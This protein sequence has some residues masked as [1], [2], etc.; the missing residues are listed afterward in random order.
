MGFSLC[1]I[2]GLLVSPVSWT[3]HWTLAV[4]ALLLLALRVVRE[5]SKVGIAAVTAI[6]LVG[7]S[8]VPKLMAKPAFAPSGV[9]PVAWTLAA[10]PYVVTGLVALTV[11]LVPEARRLV[12]AVSAKRPALRRRVAVPAIA[13]DMK[14]TR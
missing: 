6:A 14:G 3:H 8:Y 4:P 7:Y 2:T 13:H 10:G 1:A 9:R 11:A 5:R 12:Y